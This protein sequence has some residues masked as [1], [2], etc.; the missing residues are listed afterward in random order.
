MR[1]YTFKIVPRGLKPD[2]DGT[3]NT[4]WLSVSMNLKPTGGGMETVGAPLFLRRLIAEEQHPFPQMIE[5][6]GDLWMLGKT[7]VYRV[8][9]DGYQKVRLRHLDS[10][11]HPWSAAIFPGFAVISN[12]KHLY[13]LKDGYMV[14][15]EAGLDDFS[16]QL[17]VC[18]AMC[19]WNGQIISGNVWAWGEQRKNAVLWSKVGDADQRALREGAGGAYMTWGGEILAIHGLDAGPVIYGEQGISLLAPAPHPAGFGERI[20]DMG[21]GLAGPLAVTGDRQRHVFLA[22]DGTLYG[23]DERGVQRLGFTSS[24]V[25]AAGMCPS[26]TMNRQ[27]KEIFIAF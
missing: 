27:T 10:T 26:L 8:R 14:P 5:V 7:R 23:L 20:I 19:G 16:K 24:M 25:A 17:P 13:R 21:L 1:E 2:D 22:R 4:N 11:G 3:I 6:M 15:E 9:R 18:R 12:F